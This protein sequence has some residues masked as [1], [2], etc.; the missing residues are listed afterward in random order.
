MHQPRG[1]EPGKAGAHVAQRVADRRHLA[2]IVEPE[3]VRAEPVVDVVGVVGDV[4]GDGGGLRL[5]AG[6]APQHE[7][8]RRRIER[9]AHRASLSTRSVAAALDR[10]PA[11]G[12][13]RRTS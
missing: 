13:R 4:V 3:Q 2:E 10:R 12:M 5:G 1:L 8:G 7:I 6:V 9:N 11:R